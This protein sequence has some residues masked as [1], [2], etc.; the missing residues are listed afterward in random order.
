MASSASSA[1]ASSNDL[2]FW[3]F[4]VVCWILS[5]VFLICTALTPKTGLKEKMYPESVAKL[6]LILPVL[7]MSCL[8]LGLLG[9]IGF[10]CGFLLG[11]TF[12]ICVSTSLVPVPERF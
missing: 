6:V 1:S 8:G 5:I 10:I 3:A 12:A 2:K 11:C 9:W 7:G 4:I